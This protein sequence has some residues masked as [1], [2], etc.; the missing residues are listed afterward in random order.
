ML[1]RKIKS[2]FRRDPNKRAIFAVQHGSYKGDFFVLMNQTSE[3]VDF[4]SLPDNKPVR[5]TTKQF[6]DGVSNKIVEL[7]ERLP[8]N[9]Y[10]ICQA[11]YNETKA[12]H[13]IDRLKQSVTQSG[14]DNGEREK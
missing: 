4:L 5:M 13:D 6:E 2:I 9:V 14:V 12:R 1:L 8:Y 7:V 3:H 10:Q 11:Q